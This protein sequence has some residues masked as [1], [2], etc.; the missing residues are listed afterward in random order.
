M[1][2]S[3][4]TLMPFINVDEPKNVTTIFEPDAEDGYLEI[5]FSIDCVMFGVLPFGIVASVLTLIVLRHVN[6]T[7]RLPFLYISVLTT[8]DGVRLIMQGIVFIFLQVLAV[9]TVFVC[10]CLSVM[11]YTTVLYL[12]SL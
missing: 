2:A 4:N 10:I 6:L 9:K 1:Q 7:A 11:I 12:F 3:N 8:L 5:M